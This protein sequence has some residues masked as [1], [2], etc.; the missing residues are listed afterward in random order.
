M[1][2]IPMNAPA[3]LHRRVCMGAEGDQTAATGPLLILAHGL[4]AIDPAQRDRYW[5]T[6]TMGDL[7]PRQ[8]EAAL[9]AWQRGPRG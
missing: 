6:G 7:S 8:V 4:M 2:P 3:E 9:H 5:I 1:R